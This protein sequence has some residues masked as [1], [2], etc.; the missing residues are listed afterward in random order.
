MPENDQ[1][2]NNA[3]NASPTSEIK[4]NGNVIP[5]DYNLVSLVVYN[6][7]NRIAQARF[8]FLDGDASKADFPL[9]NK[10]DFLP[11]STIEISA[12]YKGNNQLIFKGMVV[13]HSIKLKENKSTFLLV[14][15]RHDA[16]K[17][18]KTRKNK[19]FTSQKDSD[20]F[21]A[22]LQPYNITAN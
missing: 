1:Q 19:I 3:S 8:I 15:C 16:V 22:I 21:S 18:T 11:G 10:P 12:G 6:C 13:K 14:D 20:I 7:I 4:V 5:S 9:S 17:A 2:N